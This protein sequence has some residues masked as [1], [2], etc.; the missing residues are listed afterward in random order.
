M[1]STALSLFVR[2]L[3]A[4]VLARVLTSWFRPRFRTRENGWFFTID[5][6]IWRAT[7]PFMAPIRNILPGGGM[8]M[9]FSP[10]V[11]FFLIRLVG[12][13]LVSMLRSAGL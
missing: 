9:D 10:I 11:L 7:E 12:G 6:Y 1:L 4:L 13:V 3:Y 2:I 8:G 5:D